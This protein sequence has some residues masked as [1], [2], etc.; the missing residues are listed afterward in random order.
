[1]LTNKYSK[2][3]F[4]IV[5]NASKLNRDGYVEKHHIIPKSLG[6]SND[7]T[8]LV[9]LSPREHFI[10]HRLLTKM[11]EGIQKRK[12]LW[13]M[14]K[15]IYQVNQH[16]IRYVPNSRT[17]EHFRKEFYSMLKKPRVI[18]DEHRNNIIES[19]MKRKGR[20]LSEE[21]RL[22]MSEAQKKRALTHD[23]ANKGRKFSDEAK[24]AMSEAQKKRYQKAKENVTFHLR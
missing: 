15:I 21:T 10:C 23:G 5:V 14:H 22:K 13:A 7:L 2:W 20:K 8:N 4:N 11:T 18:T 3:Y 24:K 17:F 9:K 19:N 12:M 16:Q 6:G 1:M